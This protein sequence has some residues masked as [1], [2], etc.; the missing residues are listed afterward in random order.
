[1]GRIF[2]CWFCFLSGI[3]DKVIC[4]K[5]VRVSRVFVE[6]GEGLK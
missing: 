1:M 6:G 4:W 5:K 3:G 2:F